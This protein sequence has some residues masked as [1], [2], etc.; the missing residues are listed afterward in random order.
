MTK[1]FTHYVTLYGSPLGETDEL[2]REIQSLNAKVHDHEAP[3]RIDDWV[4]DGCPIETLVFDPFETDHW[5]S[6]HSYLSELASK[7]PKIGISWQY[8]DERNFYSTCFC[9]GQLQIDMQREGAASASWV[10]Q[11][12]VA[13]PQSLDETS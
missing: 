8:S 10:K 9:D 3:E 4:G 1:R 6:F 5:N 12:K 13:I 11:R 2:R 7:Y